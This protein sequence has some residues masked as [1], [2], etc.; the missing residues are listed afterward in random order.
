MEFDWKK[1][2][3]GKEADLPLK[4][5]DLVYIPDSKMRRYGEPVATSAINSMMY[6]ILGALLWR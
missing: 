3:S 1:M 2:L 5:N 6:G 4:P